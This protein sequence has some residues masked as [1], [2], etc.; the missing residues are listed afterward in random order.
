MGT[1]YRPGRLEGP[2]T[3]ADI[4]AAHDCIK[5]AIDKW[6]KYLKSAVR[7]AG[8]P[9]EDFVPYQQALTAEALGAF[10]DVARGQSLYPPNILVLEPRHI[11]ALR[12]I[13]KTFVI[14]T[15]DKLGTSF[16]FVCKKLYAKAL[17]QDLQDNAVYTKVPVAQTPLHIF[18]QT[19]EL[20]QP[21]GSHIPDRQRKLSPYFLTYKA[22]SDGYRFLVG[23]TWIL[24]YLDTWIPL[25]LTT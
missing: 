16:A 17:I 2:I 24:D 1:K 9:A 10:D 7:L 19:R 15:V 3:D 11:Q 5:R 20:L 21:L 6:V 8:L 22:H 23:S 13:Q 25:L 12:T 4:V 14:T 18:T